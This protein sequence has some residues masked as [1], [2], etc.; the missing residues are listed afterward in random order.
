RFR[1]GNLSTEDRSDWSGHVPDRDTCL[2]KS[3]RHQ[4]FLEVAGLQRPART[5]CWRWTGN[6]AGPDLISASNTTIAPPGR[7]RAMTAVAAW[8]KSSR[9]GSMTGTVDWGP[10]A[11]MSGE[12]TVPTR[13]PPTLTAPETPLMGIG[14]ALR[15]VTTS[16]SCSVAEVSVTSASW[17]GWSSTVGSLGTGNVPE[18]SMGRVMMPMGVSTPKAPFAV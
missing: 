9:T 14:K 3:R 18:C 17:G 11:P 15:L 12:L 10:M 4:R 8:A 13:E 1:P 16:G 5:F 7:C 2:D 6:L